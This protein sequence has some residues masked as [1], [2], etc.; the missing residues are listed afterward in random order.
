MH[1]FVQLK[2][3]ATAQLQQRYKI[4]SDMDTVL[5]FNEY[6]HRPM[7]SVSMSEIP[8]QTLHHVI[9]SNQY[10]ALPRLS[11]QPVL[12]ALC[13]AEWNRPRKRL[14]V[15][16]VTGVTA[17]HDAARQALRQF[18]QD[19]HYSLDR[20]RFVYLYHEKQTEFVESMWAASTGHPLL[21]IVIIWR[22]DTSHVKYEWLDSEWSV[23]Q[24]TGGDQQDGVAAQSE[25][26]ANI[27]DTKQRLEE[28]ISR[29]L[30]STE[31]LSYEAVVKV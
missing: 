30:K 7:A 29:L 18:A 20:V 17:E 23:Q 1:R 27:N 2:S 28:T 11:S 12:E 31:A 26:A 21:R 6:P 9:T 19:T 24:D 25:S 22:R 16:L 14:C 3:P 8:S 5:L 4:S 10:L 13:P 15:V